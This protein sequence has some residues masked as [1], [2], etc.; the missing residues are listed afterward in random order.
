MLMLV[1]GRY[2]L[3]VYSTGE[4]IK[5]RL[6]KVFKMVV[7]YVTPRFLKNKSM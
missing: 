3:V 4:C 1:L 2:M 5:I 7:N 6:V